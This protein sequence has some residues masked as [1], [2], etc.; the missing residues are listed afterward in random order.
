MRMAKLAAALSLL[1]WFAPR[2][3][4][5]VAVLL[6]EPYSYDGAFAGTGHTAVYLSRVCAASPTVLRRCQRG[7]PGVVMSRY[8]RI[9]GYD[10]IAIPLYPYLYAV[11]SPAEIPLFV[12]NKLEAAVRDQYRRKYLESV[13]PDGVDGATPGGDWYE[14]VGSAYDRTLYGFQIETTPAQDD[15]FIAH[16]N[17][18]PNSAS[19]KLV[20]NNC[21][22]FVRAAVNFYYP[23]AAKR[24]MISDL[25]VST[26]KHT[27]KSLAQYGKRHPELHFTAFVIPQVPGT[28]RRSRPARG[29]VE[30]VFKAKKY[31]LPLLVVQPFVAGGVGVAYAVSGRFNPAEGAMVFTHGDLEPPLSAKE[32]R[33][34]QK[35]LAEV[36]STEE[37]PGRE[38][39]SWHHLLTR[40]KLQLDKDGR[41]VLQVRSGNS[42]V[43][44][45]ITRG[46]VLSDAAPR[47]IVQELLVARLREELRSGGPPKTS[48]AELRRDWQL[49]KSAFA[50]N[51]EA[52]TARADF[53]GRGQ[54]G[55]NPLLPAAKSP[56]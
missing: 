20:S 18:G 32:R 24:S 16:Y 19:Y 1:L 48:E 13:V 5:E 22:D 55:D 34:Y 12:D 43:E 15:E 47:E 46:N 41:P 6:E 28:I 25:D 49:L 9:A 10:W 36:T 44:V 45:G 50:D 42:V 38:E 56:F 26:P 23:N 39:A 53:R 3:K 4:A 27:A 37:N 21:A 52:I 30:S 14:L 2:A 17:A 54:N 40:A 29:L 11:N 31:E 35:G 51:S 7:E 33:A 8:H